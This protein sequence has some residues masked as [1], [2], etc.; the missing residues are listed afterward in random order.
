VIHV[1]PDES[2]RRALERDLDLFG[3]ADTI[4][5]RYRRRYL[6]GQAL[7]RAHVGPRDLSDFVVDMT[8]LTEPNL[9]RRPRIP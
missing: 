6:P 1:D 3:S 9:L 8:A 2:V 4:E 7:Y 5:L